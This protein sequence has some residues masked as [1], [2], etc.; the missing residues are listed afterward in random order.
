MVKQRISGQQAYKNFGES[1]RKAYLNPT[2]L[3]KDSAV[4]ERLA[5]SGVTTLGHPEYSGLKLGETQLAKAVVGFVDIRGVTKL[6]FALESKELLRVIQAL[7]KASIRAVREGGGYIGEF[8]GDGVMT[9]FGDSSTSDEEATLAALETITLLFKSVDEIVNPELKQHGLD[10]IR[11]AAGLEFGEVLWSR[12]GIAEISQLKPIGTA[13]FLAGKLSSGKYT[14][15]W[16]CKVGAELARWI[17]D[18][19]KKKV[20]QYGPVSVNKEQFSRELY[21]FDWKQFAND[22]LLD[23]AQLEDRVR[24]RF[25]SASESPYLAALKVLTEAGYDVILDDSTESPYLLIKFDRN[26]NFAIIITFESSSA[27]AVPSVFVKQNGHFEQVE[28]PSIQWMQGSA[29]LA[30]LIAAVH[31][32]WS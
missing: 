30:A 25:A 3:T 16:E 6:S 9:Y 31:K 20:E 4:M 28:V 12:I 32:A 7:T 21:L 13:T 14:S 11:I 18:E 10:P 24:K 23:Q 29:N 1:F 5:T 27:T 2:P 19:H 17:P 15:A 22:M 26:T 8:T